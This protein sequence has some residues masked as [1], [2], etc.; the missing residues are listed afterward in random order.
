MRNQSLV[1]SPLYD[2]PYH[3]PLATV[4]SSSNRVETL[5]RQVRQLQH[6]LGREHPQLHLARSWFAV[7]HG[8]EAFDDGLLHLL[9]KAEPAIRQH[10]PDAM[11]ALAMTKGCVV[12]E[13]RLGQAC[14][15]NECR[16]AG[17]GQGQAKLVG[18]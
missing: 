7:A 2:L 1:F 9:Q 11:R 18:E 12:R 3:G 16:C 5:A 13:V 15:R 14:V 10:Y 4:E 6:E 17:A 8:A